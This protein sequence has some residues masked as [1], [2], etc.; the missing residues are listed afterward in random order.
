ML[1][2]VQCD[3]VWSFRRDDK[4]AHPR[5]SHR[6]GRQLAKAKSSL[7][8]SIKQI[9]VATGFWMHRNWFH[10]KD[11]SIVIPTK[12]SARYID[13]ILR[14]YARMGLRVI[15]FVDDSST[16]NTL[17]LCRAHCEHVEMISNSGG[18]TE[19]MIQEISERSRTDW[20]LRF[21]DDELPT[22]S[23]IETALNL[24]N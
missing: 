16:D 5:A 6:D 11:I 18:L 1:L 13:I 22:N 15:P 7:K 17:S 8:Q 23:M 24:A 4:M 19:T 20:I 3:C 14:H 21:D 2:M 12:N 10:F 9:F